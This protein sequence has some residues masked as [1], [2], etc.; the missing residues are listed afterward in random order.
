MENFT[1][2]FTMKKTKLKKT[3]NAWEYYFEKLNKYTLKSLSISKC[4]LTNNNFSKSF[5]IT[6]FALII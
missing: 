5:L 1:T 2:I 6:S 4:Y 3:F